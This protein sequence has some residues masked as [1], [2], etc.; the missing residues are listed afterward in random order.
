MTR[1]PYDQETDETFDRIINPHRHPG[2]HTMT[3]EPSTAE[4]K[5]AQAWQMMGCSSLI[6]SLAFAVAVVV[7]AWRW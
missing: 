7:A 5:K 2:G 3:R 1:E 6:V 4:D